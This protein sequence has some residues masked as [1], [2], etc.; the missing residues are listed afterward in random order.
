MLYFK[1]L[2]LQCRHQHEAIENVLFSTI[3]IGNLMKK[4]KM[5]DV[6]VD[7]VVVNV[8]VDDVVVNVVVDDVVV[9]DVVV[10]VV[11]DAVLSHALQ[12]S[13]VENLIISINQF[14][15]PPLRQPTI[16]MK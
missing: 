14:D 10:N 16:V 13:F 1:L 7:D 5:V 2:K 3:T 4:N 9:D 12:T 11:D 6:V 15:G 8:V